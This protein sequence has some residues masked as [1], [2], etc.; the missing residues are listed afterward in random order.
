MDR[1]VS[2]DNVLLNCLEKKLLSLIWIRVEPGST[3]SID[4]VLM[5]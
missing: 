5:L 4:K 3:I 1:R 2:I